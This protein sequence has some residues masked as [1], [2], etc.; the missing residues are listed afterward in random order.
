M[1][2]DDALL[3]LLERHRHFQFV[4]QKVRRRHVKSPLR[5]CS[6]EV[7]QNELFLLEYKLF[8]NSLRIAQQEWSSF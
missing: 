4:A 2:S 8:L 3:S 1:L 5:K 7:S 6:R